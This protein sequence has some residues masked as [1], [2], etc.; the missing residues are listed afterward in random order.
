MP[1]EQKNWPAPYG[2]LRVWGSSECMPQIEDPWERSWELG[3][4]REPEGPG[5][6]PAIGECC[7]EAGAAKALQRG[8]RPHEAEAHVLPWGTW[9][10]SARQN[11]AMGGLWSSALESGHPSYPYPAP[12]IHLWPSLSQGRGRP[13]TLAGVVFDRGQQRMGL[14][15]RTH[16]SACPTKSHPFQAAPFMH[17][18]MTTVAIPGPAGLAPVRGIPWMVRT[19]TRGC[20]ELTSRGGGWGEVR[21]PTCN[22]EAPE[23]TGH[24]SCSQRSRPRHCPPPAH[25]SWTLLLGLG[26]EELCGALATRAESEMNLHARPVA[27]FPQP[28]SSQTPASVP[29]HLCLSGQRGPAQTGPPPGSS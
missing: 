28:A 4:F 5:K 24:A 2:L 16:I 26:R 17:Q 20:P 1:W 9:P 22:L 14:S 15:L 10:L 8:Q 25:S 13:L 11:L 27:E 3:G 12:Q 19:H 21:E 18:A 29:S 7:G 23:V 6:L